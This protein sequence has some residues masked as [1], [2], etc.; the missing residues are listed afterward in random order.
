VK[1]LH[2]IK[3]ALSIN[4]HMFFSK[5]PVKSLAIFGSFSRNEQKEKSDIDILVDFSSK[6]GIEFIDLAEEL[7]TI[8]ELP[9]DL[10]S[11]NGIKDKYFNEIDS[12]FI[13]V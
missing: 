9:V 11:R 6:I 5:Y 4:K 12:D 8:I 2:E 3:D 10:V 7:E 13:Y 1:S